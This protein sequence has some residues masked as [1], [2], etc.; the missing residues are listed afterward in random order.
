MKLS[1]IIPTI[2]RETLSKVLQGICDC[3]DFDKINPEVIIVFDGPSW[4]LSTDFTVLSTE[5]KKGVSSARNLGIENSTGDILVFIGDDTIPTKSWLKNVQNFHVSHPEKNMGL[6]GMVNW[7]P[8]LA[9]DSFHQWLLN[10]A[11]FSF[12]SIRKHGATWRHFYTSN[13]SV[14]KELVG[15][16]RFPEDFSG[17]GFEDILF[18]YELHKKGLKLLFDENCEVL[19]DHPQTLEEVLAHT[20]NARKNAKAFEEKTGIT[21]L[22]QGFKLTTLRLAI[23][24]GSIFSFLSPKIGWWVEWK[25]D[26]VDKK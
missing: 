17:W 23:F 24:L 3:E 7:V 14:K 2:G 1:I 4:N 20:R 12:S 9:K 13:I 8:E 10:N 25:R 26:W 16:I 22:P 19:H 5:D 11:Q 21:V 6:L 18:G 15:N